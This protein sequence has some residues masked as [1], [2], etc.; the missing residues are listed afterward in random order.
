MA[1][2]KKAEKNKKQNESEGIPMQRP[3]QPINQPNAGSK[4]CRKTKS[5]N[6]SDP[7]ES[8]EK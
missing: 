3:A 4:P 6:A 7:I 1:E 5:Q 2:A 8:G